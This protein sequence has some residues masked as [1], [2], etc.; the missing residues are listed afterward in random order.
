MS[1][2][3]VILSEIMVYTEQPALSLLL[4]GDWLHILQQGSGYNSRS[5]GKWPGLSQTDLFSSLGPQSVKERLWS[6]LSGTFLCMLSPHTL[7]RNKL[8]NPLRSFRSGPLGFIGCLTQAQAEPVSETFFTLQLSP[9]S[10]RPLG[11]FM[12]LSDQC[13]RDLEHTLPMD[14]QDSACDTPLKN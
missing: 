1:L 11:I 5:W 12:F 3:S 8:G 2:S 14:C 13:C 9:H 4:L 6:E 7:A 10:P